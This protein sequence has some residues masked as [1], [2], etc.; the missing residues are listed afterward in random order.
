MARET[1]PVHEGSAPSK[2]GPDVPSNDSEI[3]APPPGVHTMAIVRWILIAVMAVVAALS[4]TY[5]FGLVSSEA[6]G[7]TSVQYYCPMHPQVVQDHPGECPICSMTLV[8]KEGGSG[9][10]SR[11]DGGAT[12]TAGAPMS[13]SMDDEGAAHEGHRHNPADPY[14]CPMHPRETGV[15]DSARCPICAMKLERRPVGGAA[16]ATQIPDREAPGLSPAPVETGTV[17]Q[18]RDVPGLVPVQL[19]M[20][21]VQTIGVRTAPA[22]VEELSAELRTV[23]YVTADE[24]KLARVHTRFSGWIEE[25]A[26]PT[27]GQKVARGQKLAG[28]YNLELLPAEQ[29]FLAA[30]RWSSGGAPSESAPGTAAHI[31]SGSLEQ[32]ARSRLELFGLSPA[33]IDRIAQTGRPIRTVAVTAPISGHVISKNAVLGAYVQP[34][35]E[36]FEIADLT[37]V[38]VLGDVYEYEAGR[39]RVGQAADVVLPAYPNDR[40]SGKIGFIYPVVDPTTR[41]LRV[42]VEL[43]N[44]GLRLKPGMYGDVVVHLDPER[45]VVIPTEALAD[46]GEYQYVFLARDGGRFEPR[47]V[48]AGNRSGDNVQILEGVS[49]GDLV[50]TTAGFLIDSES[51]LRAAIEGPPE[52]GV[53]PVA[54]SACDADFDKGK[55]PDKHA[56]CR[57]CERVHRGMGSMEEDCRNAIPRPWR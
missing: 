51:R 1:S 32:D 30:R 12:P 31:V 2:G 22:M 11:S 49:P 47:R 54:A 21:R 42:R 3:E 19:D 33:E 13:T 26:V 23:G 7:A 14:Y 28:L 50:V 48:R 5:S 9:K 27:T 40:F 10:P 24:A 41:T 4:V 45:G 15:D 56:Q 53:A 37:R 46:T 34:G 52:P 43:N 39:V 36:L 57:E 16:K 25:L 18:S 6:A 17:Q 44:A 55:F 8:K 29:E 38:W 35:T 20:D